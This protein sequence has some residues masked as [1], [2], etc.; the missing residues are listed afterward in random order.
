MAKLT[1]NTRER[2]LLLHDMLAESDQAHPIPLSQLLERL[3]RAG[4]AASRKSVYRDLDA[5]GRSPL[6]VTHRQKDPK[7]WYAARRPPVPQETRQIL[8]RIYA[9]LQTRRAVSFR[10]HQG[11][12]CLVSPR[13]LLWL[14]EGYQLFGW[15]HHA[16]CLNCFPLER[17]EGVVV[18]GFPSR[19][20][21]QRQTQNS[22]R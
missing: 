8:D 18:T 19:D 5:L 21:R 12:P 16:D 7:G 15:D 3:A 2:M 13:G 4:C 1:G 9:A 10:L 14:G 17:M 20:A 22:G 11:E 6:R